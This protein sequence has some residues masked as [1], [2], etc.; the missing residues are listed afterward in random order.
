MRRSLLLSLSG[1]ALLAT[2]CARRESVPSASSGAAPEAS[3]A[4][5]VGGASSTATPQ[6][7]PDGTPAPLND[8]SCAIK[9]SGMPAR[10][11]AG[12]KPAATTLTVTNQGTRPWIV[13]MAGK[14]IERTVAISYRW[15]SNGSQVLEGDRALLASDLPPGA[16][17][18]VDMPV[19]LPGTPGSYRIKFEPVQ[20]Q[21]SW[22]SDKGGCSQEMGV[23][24]ER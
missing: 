1:L 2:A 22:F 5:R 7:P 20:E 24:V 4:A 6:S 17:K 12:A 15:F 16:T 3:A 19:K 11:K 8:F 23:T 10:V 14:P 21:V 13:T 18:T 9:Q